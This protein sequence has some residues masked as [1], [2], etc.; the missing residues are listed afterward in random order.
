[1]NLAGSAFGQDAVSDEGG[2]GVFLHLNSEFCG[3][4][5]APKVQVLPRGYDMYNCL[6][7]RV[8]D[9]V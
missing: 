4:N 3:A 6:S 5:F 2:S 8:P 9:A 7:R 1:M